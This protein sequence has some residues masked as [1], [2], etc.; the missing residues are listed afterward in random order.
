MNVFLGL[1]MPWV[2]ATA[3]E[4][5]KY[6]GPNGHNGPD[7]KYEG[8]FVPAASLGFS[9]FVFCCLALLCII[10]LFVRRLKIGGE[11]GGPYNTRVA[12]CVLLVCFWTI[13]IILSIVQT[14]MT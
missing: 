14:G 6:D 7:F 13:Y 1:G 10:F 8:L 3:I 4:S 9:V 12:S 2:I 11:L 5:A